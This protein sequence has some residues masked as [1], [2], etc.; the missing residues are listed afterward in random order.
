M[1]SRPRHL[2]HIAEP[3]YGGGDLE[4]VGKMSALKT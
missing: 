2:V 1:V 4:G 3:G